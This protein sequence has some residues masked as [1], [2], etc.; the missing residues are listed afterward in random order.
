MQAAECVTCLPKAPCRY[1]DAHDALPY[2]PQLRPSTARLPGTPLSTRP[3]PCHSKHVSCL[4]GCCCKHH[5]QPCFAAGAKL[6][7]DCLLLE[8][9]KFQETTWLTTLYMVSFRPFVPFPRPKNAVESLWPTNKDPDPR[10]AAANDITDAHAEHQ[11]LLHPDHVLA[12][13]A[14]GG[15]TEHSAGHVPA[16]TQA[17]Q[18][19]RKQ[20]CK[21][22]RTC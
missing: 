5:R 19:A 16:A 11:Q 2:Q 21:P 7:Q 9:R 3:S 4:C 18:Q 17:Q 15:N 8:P 13:K 10:Y 20:A 6:R 1:T 14:L 12:G 22:S